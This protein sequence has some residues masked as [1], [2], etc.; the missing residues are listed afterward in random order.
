MGTECPKC[1][2]DNPADTSFCGK[3]GAELN[4]DEQGKKGG[5]QTKEKKQASPEK[6]PSFS[7]TK[8]LETPAVGLKRGAVFAGRYEVIEGLGAG[9]RRQ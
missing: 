5:P 7:V 3:C 6:T 2:Q 9:C 4:P 1:R 8:T